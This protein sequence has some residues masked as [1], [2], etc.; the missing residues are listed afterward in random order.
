MKSSMRASTSASLS[1]RAALGIVGWADRLGADQLGG[2]L[3]AGMVKL[4]RRHRAAR[5]DLGR[6]TLHARQMIVGEHAEL[7]GKALAHALD[8]GRAGHHQAEASGGAPGQPVELVVGKLAVVM[9]LGIG[10]RGQ[11]EAVLHRRAAGEGQRFE[12]VGHG[13]LSCGWRPWDST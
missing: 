7:A 8:V 12:E 2:R 13:E 9:A 3:D 6:Q 10:Q 4:D 1:A 11:H 5:P